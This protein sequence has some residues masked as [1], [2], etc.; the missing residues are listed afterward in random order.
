MSDNGVPVDVGETQLDR[1]FFAGLDP[2]GVRLNGDVQDAFLRWNGEFLLFGVDLAAKDGRRLNED[3]RLVGDLDRHVD[4]SQTIFQLDELRLAHRNFPARTRRE[5]DVSVRVVRS[6]LEMRDVPDRIFRLVGDDFERI[7]PVVRLGVGDLSNAAHDDELSALL[8]YPVVRGND[9][10]D[11]VLPGLGGD[12]LSRPF[13]LFVGPEL[14]GVD[15]RLDRL[16]GA[17]VGLGIFNS[18]ELDDRGAGDALAVEPTRV[19]S[20]IHRVAD[21]EIAAIEPDVGLERAPRRVDF[22]AADDRSARLVRYFGGDFVLLVVVRIDQLGERGIDGDFKVAVLP[23]LRFA[24]GDDF[25]H[26]GRL[27]HIEEREPHASPMAPAGVPVVVVSELPVSASV[28]PVPISRGEIGRTVVRPNHFIGD[29]R[30]C[31][32]GSEVVFRVDLRFERVAERDRL[33]RRVDRYLEFRL[34]VFFEPER[35]VPQPGIDG[36]IVVEMSRKLHGVDAE[37][38]VAGNFKGVAER[39]VFVERNALFG[40][41]LAARGEYLIIELLARPFRVVR[42]VVSSVPDDEFEF[43]L[44]VRT[45]DGPVGDEEGARVLEKI[46]AGINAPNSLEI[47]EGVL[48]RALFVAPVFRNDRENFGRVLFFNFVVG[49]KDGPGFIGSFRI[50]FGFDRVTTVGPATIDN[51]EFDRPFGKRL[52]RLGVEREVAVPVLKR[53][54]DDGDVAQPDDS[55]VFVPVRRGNFDKVRARLADREVDAL[56]FV[57]MVRVGLKLNGVARD[58]FAD[59]IDLLERFEELPL[60][61]IELFVRLI[62]FR[63]ELLAQNEVDHAVQVAVTAVILPEFVAAH[64]LQRFVDVEPLG[65]DFRADRVAE[66]D[67]QVRFR[68]GDDGAGVDRDARIDNL[69]KGRFRLFED[70]VRNVLLVKDLLPDFGG[71]I[72]LASVLIL[73]GEIDEHAP[74]GETPDLDNFAPQIDIVVFRREFEPFHAR[75]ELGDRFIVGERVQRPDPLLARLLVGAGIF[76]EEEPV[77]RKGLDAKDLL[78]FLS[79]HTADVRFI[80]REFFDQFVQER[81]AAFAVVLSRFKGLGSGKEDGAARFVDG[82]AARPVLTIDVRCREIVR[83]DAEVGQGLLTPVVVRAAPMQGAGKG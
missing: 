74:V 77:G 4:V 45:V 33:F 14:V 16:H 40:D 1:R 15:L 37:F 68:T 25:R 63:Q 30:V 23:N 49:E 22:A 59:K 5:E 52:A 82:R 57:V 26:A 3:V 51:K 27:R 19:D 80:G 8:R 72:E 35:A 20:K 60:L 10:R 32:R 67:I 54:A 55:D 36:S 17:V 2:L 38:R 39:A 42:R 79:A 43:R 62:V 65:D 9:A 24:F 66:S 70:V 81:L 53:L 13:A 7:E 50:S 61:R 64:D 18:I 44:L 75:C 69:R 6:D 11:A 48:R 56:D 76:V 34:A 12:K 73:L 31:D 41:F 71:F 28:E 29:D 78:R 83:E 47:H 21:P 46:V 58:F